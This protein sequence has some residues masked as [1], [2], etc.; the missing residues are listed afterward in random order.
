M[1]VSNEPGETDT[2]R[3]P[4]TPNRAAITLLYQRQ[5]RGERYGFLAYDPRPARRGTLIS[6]TVDGE[7]KVCPSAS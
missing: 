3:A 1:G 7:W 6:E 4:L 5:H 2:T